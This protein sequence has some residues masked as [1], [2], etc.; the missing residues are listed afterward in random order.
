MKKTQ[1][2]YLLNK[3]L[4]V[5]RFAKI[6]IAADG[7][8]ANTLKTLSNKFN[9]DINEIDI[10]FPESNND[11]IKFSL[12][13]LNIDLDNACKKIDLIRLP[14]HKR[15]RKLLLLKLSLMHKDK[16]FYKKIFLNLL[17]PKRDMFLP[18]QLYKS[19]DQ[20][21]FIAGDTSTDFNF[22]T[23]RLILGSIYIRVVLFFFNNNNQSEMED[24]LDAS[25]RRVSKIPKLKSKI[26][27]F[28][29]SLPKILKFVKSF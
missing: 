17:I 20:I 6:L 11:L 28:K 13:Q 2:K 1:N 3:R 29:D 21:W 7:F 27:T 16:I 4:E 19:I 26:N 9:L 12:E 8:K 18:F 14:V 5:L 24:I 23:K 25:L 22:Y 15:I 10:L